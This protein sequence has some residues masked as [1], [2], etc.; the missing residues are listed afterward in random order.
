MSGGNTA[1]DGTGTFYWLLLDAL[2]R[3]RINDEW[4][5]TLQADENANDS[6][7]TIVVTSSYEWKIQW[8][9]IEFTSTSTVGD[10][11][12][13][14]EIQ[15]ATTDVI[16]QM[17]AGA[18]QAASLTR[19]YLFAPMG[20]EIT[21]FR[22]TDYL[23]APMPPIHLPASYVIRI[24]DNNAVDAAADDMIIQMMVQERD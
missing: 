18:V 16:F 1:K 10:R 3:L 19:Y 8:I 9:W 2:G 21:T 4:T 5:P 23:Y 24:Y 17:R 11:Q 15:D 22:D 14:I 13:V 20:A 7:K 6:D 12:V